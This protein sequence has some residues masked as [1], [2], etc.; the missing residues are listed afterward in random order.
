MFDDMDK[1]TD[2]DFITEEYEEI[3][4]GEALDKILLAIKEGEKVYGKS[5]SE[6]EEILIDALLWDKETTLEMLTLCKNIEA[7]RR[8][9]KSVADEYME[10]WWRTY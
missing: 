9:C 8:T 2:S 1:L 4:E 10:W 3:G 5:A 6:L 7:L